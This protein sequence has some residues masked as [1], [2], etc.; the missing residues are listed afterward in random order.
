MVVDANADQAVI[1]TKPDDWP[2][3]EEI[4]MKALFGNHPGGTETGFCDG[5]VHFLRET[6][7]PD[8]L[9]RLMTRDGGE[10]IGPDEY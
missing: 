6:V 5:S 10:V 9:R 3:G 7:N 2:V 4:D 1:W 8:L